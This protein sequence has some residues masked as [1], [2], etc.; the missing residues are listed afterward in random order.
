MA[1]S[2]DRFGFDVARLARLWRARL[3][4]RLA[5]LGLTQARWAVLL[6]LSRSGGRLPQRALVELVGVEGP[7]LVRLLDGL[8]RAGLIE[9]RDDRIDRRAKTVHLKAAAQP[10]VQ[11][12]AKIAAQV[13]LEVMDGIAEADLAACQRV[14]A[15]IAENF[16]ALLPSREM[17][18]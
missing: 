3:D 11:Q 1:R 7:T 18:P 15:R 5:P 4:S 16:D 2:Y 14:F 12:I 10:L 17:Q 13:R 9:R 8:E 6:H